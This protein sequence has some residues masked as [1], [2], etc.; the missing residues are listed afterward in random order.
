MAEV[1]YSQT[2]IKHGI[3]N[4]P[5]E[6]H[7]KAL[8]RIAEKVFQPA[9]EALGFPIRVSSGYRS[10]ALNKRIGGASASQHSKGEALDLK[11]PPGKK[12]AELFSFIYNN[13][14]YDQLIWEF[15][16]EDEPA[17]IH[18]SYSKGVNRKETLVAYKVNGRTK[19]KYYGQ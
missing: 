19:Y 12:N 16:D 9:R 5:S 1:T 13:L 11:V 15:G 18:V 10:G 3:S 7:L 2:A 6:A 8:R 17:W 4:M 14:E